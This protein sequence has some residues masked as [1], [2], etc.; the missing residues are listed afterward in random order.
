MKGIRYFII[1]FLAV[2]IV[3][4]VTPTTYWANDN[5]NAN[6]DRDKS[7]CIAYSQGYSPMANPNFGLTTDP[8]LQALGNLMQMQQA[9]SKRQALFEYCMMNLGWYQVEGP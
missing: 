8:D 7:R 5:P 2:A 1:L 4:C 3:G 6:F 9:Q